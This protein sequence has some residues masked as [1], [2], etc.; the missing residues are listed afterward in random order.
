MKLKMKKRVLV[1]KLIIAVAIIAVAVV[2]ARPIR[3]IFFDRA[4][5]KSIMKSKI[6][7]KDSLQNI[8]R[9]IKEDPNNLERVVRNSGYSR[10]N[11][12]MLKIIA[13][14]R[15]SENRR[16]ETGL[17]LG[18]AAATII[19]LIILFAVPVK[20]KEEKN[21]EEERPCNQTDTQE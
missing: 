2:S 1:F 7:E 4:Q 10:K 13:P 12:T 20:T 6:A 18:I 9:G 8:L 16:I 17:F 11:E 3:A 19:L 21:K 5:T 14:D 15:E